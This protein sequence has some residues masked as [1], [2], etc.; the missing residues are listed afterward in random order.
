M[1]VSGSTDPITMSRRNFTGT[2]VSA[3]LL[4]FDTLG[5]N[6]P[7]ES[8]PSSAQELVS[9][10]IERISRQRGV[11]AIRELKKDLSTNAFI[12]HVI[13]MVIKD[14]NPQIPLPAIITQLESQLGITLLKTSSFSLSGDPL[15]Y[16]AQ[17]PKLK[18]KRKYKTQANTIEITRRRAELMSRL[19]SPMPTM[20]L[21]LCQH[22]KDTSSTSYNNI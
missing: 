7:G 21:N 1:S 11:D 14:L 17:V 4:S 2:A 6:I 12:A 8:L 20:A 10:A 22:T 18:K 16:K 3:P 19:G 9:L 15:E 5:L 13:P